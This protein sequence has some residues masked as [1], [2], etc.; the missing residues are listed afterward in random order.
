LGSRFGY[1]LGACRFGYGLGAC[2][3]GYGLDPCLDAELSRL[4]RLVQQDSDQP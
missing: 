4:R 3:F 1:G 2:Q